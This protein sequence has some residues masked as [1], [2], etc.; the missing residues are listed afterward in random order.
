MAKINAATK[1]KPNVKKVPI[2]TEKPGRLVTIDNPLGKVS[3]D[4]FDYMQ[5]VDGLSIP[6]I[7]EMAKRGENGTYN[8]MKVEPPPKMTTES[9]DSDEEVKDKNTPVY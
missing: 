7:R 5:Y 8:L 2:R 9:S 3:E 6:E 4:Q 1:E